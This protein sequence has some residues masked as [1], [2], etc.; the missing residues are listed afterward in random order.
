MEIIPYI[1][2]LATVFVATF[3]AESLKDM[4]YL[5]ITQYIR[6][7]I[8]LAAVFFI[9][10]TPDFS[11][12]PVITALWATIESLGLVAAIF[13]SKDMFTP[14]KIY[15]RNIDVPRQLLYREDKVTGICYV[16]T[17]AEAQAAHKRGETVYI[18]AIA[19]VKYETYKNSKTSSINTN[20]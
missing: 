11:E 2:G 8:M 16:L 9:T 4:G 5:R 17:D 3:A 19:R 10:F 18:H 6:T 1:I 20:L 13:Y 14:Q 15:S 7:C 12:N